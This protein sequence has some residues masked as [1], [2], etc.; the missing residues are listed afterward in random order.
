MQAPPSVLLLMVAQVAQHLLLVLRAEHAAQAAREV[1]GHQQAWH[2]EQGPP[3]VP[4]EVACLH[5]ER[6]LRLYACLRVKPWQCQE[7]MLSAAWC[8]RCV[9]PH[10]R[11]HGTHD[12]VLGGVRMAVGVGAAGRLGCCR[13][14]AG[15]QLQPQQLICAVWP[16]APA[17]QVKPMKGRRLLSA[18]VW[19]AAYL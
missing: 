13:L 12:L 7:Q 18:A 19:H 16:L 5:L 2:E 9:R 3:I 14:G 4:R 1:A 11:L 8:L 6:F 17:H 10:A 15:S